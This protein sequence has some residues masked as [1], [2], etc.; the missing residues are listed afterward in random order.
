MPERIYKEDNLFNKL[1]ALIG[2]LREECPWDKAQ[3]L[4]SLRTY[5]LEETYEVLEA[6]EQAETNGNWDRL[7]DELGDLLLQVAFYARIA[8]E[9]DAFNLADVVDGL[10]DKM[11]YRHPHVFGDARP[12]DLSRQWESLKDAEHAD[13]KS[14]M[15]GIPPLPALSLAFKQQK[16]AARVG[17]DW[18]KADDVLAKMDEELAEFRLEVEQSSPQDRLEDEFGDVLFTLV[19]LGRKLGLDAELALMR[20]NHKFKRRF[21]HMEKMAGESSTNLDSCDLNELEAMWQ[22]AKS[23]DSGS[24]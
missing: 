12:A 19:N 6:I 1:E 9:Q 14:L 22:Q 23:A 13:R 4:S 11:I 18:C 17:F 24:S 15:D 7:K 20:S 3:T 16:R 10:I 5:T 21:M 8:K 2:V